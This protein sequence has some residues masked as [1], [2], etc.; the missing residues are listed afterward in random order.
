MRVACND[1]DDRAGLR[2]YVQFH[3]YTYIHTLIAMWKH[4]KS[5]NILRILISYLHVERAIGQGV[6]KM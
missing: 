3:K 5:E 2:G 6:D 4:Q 1:L